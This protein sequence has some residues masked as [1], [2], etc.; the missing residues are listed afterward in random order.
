MSMPS[1]SEEVA[2]TARSRPD[3][4]ASSM[5]ARRSLDTDPWWAMASSGGAPRETSDGTMSCAGGR[6]GGSG[7]EPG[8][9][10]SA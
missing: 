9:V 3:L 10:S 5:I 7:S 6:A 1:S 8:S 2:T 4:S